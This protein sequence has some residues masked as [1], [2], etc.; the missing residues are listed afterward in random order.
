LLVPPSP[1]THPAAVQL[2][3]YAL[4]KLSAADLN[5]VAQHLETCPDCLEVAA[6]R[7]A[8][9]F[10]RKLQAAHLQDATAGWAPAD[11]VAA[12]THPRTELADLPPELRDSTKYRIERELGRG[13]MGIIYLAE[14]R[15]MGKRVALKVINQTLLSHPD[16]QARFLT[17]VR[18][19]AR[20]DH[21]NIVK[22]LDADRLGDLHLLVMDYVE[23]RS[24]AE[25]LQRKGPFPVVHACNYI[26]QAA[27]GL[28]HAF[29]QGMVHRD[30]KPQNLMLTRDGKVKILDF[31][32]ARIARERPLGKPGL[33][34]VGDFMGTPEYVAPEQAM[35]ASSADIRAD[36]Y[37]LGCTM[38]FLLA[39]R[40][41]FEEGT[42]VGTIMAHLEKE[43]MPLPTVRADV[44]AK[45][46]AVLARVLEKDPKQRYEKPVELAQALA[47]FCRPGPK[48]PPAAPKPTM[49][50][51]SSPHALTK[52]A[53]DTSQL[54]RRHAEAP[55]VAPV[56]VPPPCAELDGPQAPGTLQ[57]QA[58]P[59][60]FASRR[61]I[62]LGT[63]IG[64]GVLL[65]AVGG[66][67]LSGVIFRVATP[68]GTLVLE[69]DQPGATVSVDGE[70]VR[71][72]WSAGGK[73]AEVGVKPG[74]RQVSVAKDGF[75]THGEE[76]IVEDGGRRII[77]VRLE[78][79]AARTQPAAVPEQGKAPPNTFVP[80]FNGKD[81]TGWKSLSSSR[82]KWEV[83]DGIL[84]GEGDQGYLFNDGKSYENFH[85]RVEAM[86]NGGGNSGVLFRA[87]FGPTTAQGAPALGYEADINITHN[88]HPH[89]TGS[90]HL[91][92]HRTVAALSTT[93]TECDMWFS[94]EVI[95]DGPRIVVQVNGKVTATFIDLALGTRIG[96]IALQVADAATVVKF[97]KIEI[98]ELP[99]GDLRLQ[100]AH[101][102][103]GW[104]QVKG[105]V[106]LERAG[107]WLGYFRE[108][109]RNNDDDGGGTVR[110]SRKFDAK[111]TF[112]LHITRGNGA[113]GNFL[114]TRQWFRH[115]SGNWSVLPRTP[116]PQR[117][118]AA[119]VGEWVALLN[120]KDLRG[121]ETAGNQNATWIY[122]GDALVGRSSADPAGLM[123]S[124]RADYENFH[125]RM[126]TKLSEGTY[127][128]LFLRCGPPNDGTAG[129]KCYALRLG[130]SN[131]EPPLTGSLV[132]SA[133][134]DEVVPFPLADASKISLQTDAWFALE[135]IAE[136]N[137]LRVL[138]DGKT[139]VD[140]I[141]ANETFMVGRLGLV[142]RGNAVVRFRKLEIKELPSARPG[143][144][145]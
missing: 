40:P 6:G 143:P 33:T 3:A 141:D 129:N 84:I 25:V 60:R 127:S 86:I 56:V 9:S 67:L 50:P 14:H 139:V 142:C 128:S 55:L 76:V 130:A 5:T 57:K 49:L 135:V 24:L 30:I 15:M 96:R 99:P 97:R 38:Y 137:H 117:S 78:R 136:G 46:W 93:P 72:T 41:P 105:N 62:A 13:G 26:R 111:K 37:S 131:G 36:L 74:T 2:Q 85:L 66:W 92:G 22:A 4:G 48:P 1:T 7:H 73:K 58:G 144:S 12:R 126:E 119:R 100:Y 19:A 124:D 113:W 17:E 89:K 98:K 27:L 101:G 29:E 28:Q 52:M 35:D 68:D 145:S 132:L 43:A 11:L 21:P 75:M 138:I 20:L 115:S 134:L 18:A 39:A 116:P 81:L 53:G 64:L 140:Y 108:H 88:L 102:R 23:G 8:D 16:A 77:A 51:V 87:P 70:K 79:T 125:L 32:L 71:V 94:L 95:A 106:W 133:H 114:G 103:G 91:Y 112:V 110:L 122:E 45:L 104:E 80:L 69:V 61:K 109:A 83:K 123:L 65:L 42:A 90:L 10:V 82:A 118:P 63:Q 34:Q 44:P 59:G 31:G 107:A 121:W 120:G 47:P 54:P